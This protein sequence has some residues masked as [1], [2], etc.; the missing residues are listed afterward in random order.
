[1]EEE[2]EEVEAEVEDKKIIDCHCLLFRSFLFILDFC[3]L[4]FFCNN[5]ETKTNFT[6]FTNP[7][8]FFIDL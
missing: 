8:F 4:L 3:S 6:Y 1:V 2:E 5:K 7:F